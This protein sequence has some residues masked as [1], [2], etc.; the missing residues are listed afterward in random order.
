MPDQPC[1]ILLVEPDGEMLEMLVA[2][3]S[4][5]V[6]AHLTCVSDAERCLDVELSD[7]HDLVISELDLTPS[8]TSL[9]RADGPVRVGDGLKLCEQLLG[10]SNRPVILL[11]DHLTC[12]EA[13]SALRIGVR[14]VMPKPFPVGQLLE[15]ADRALSGLHLRRTRAAK[16][17]HMRSIVRRVVRERRD[18]QQ[19]LTACQQRV[20]LV[21]RDLVGAQRRLTHRL[22]K[23]Q[24]NGTSTPP[25]GG[26]AAP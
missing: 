24:D 17:R 14:D 10:L 16:Y 18:L 11:A 2:A 26:L 6:Y 9:R 7:P 23:L 3:I 25:R 1:K 12:D 13:V 20:E 8:P 15:A 4:R 21:C 19:R 5:H 22:A